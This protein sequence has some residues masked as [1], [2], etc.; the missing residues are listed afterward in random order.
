MSQ[1]LKW[2]GIS[3][4]VGGVLACLLTPLMSIGYY[5]SY[6]IPAESPPFWFASVQPLVGFLFSFADEKTAYSAY[7]RFFAVVYLLF[8]PGVLA[9]HKLHEK[10]APS[11]L[12]KIAYFLLVSALVVSFFG[13]S[14]DYW[15]IKA[16]WTVEL[17][18]M[19]FLQ[20]ATTLY[21]IAVLRLKIVPRSIAIIM[22]VSVPLCIISFLLFKQI[23]AAPS[24]PFATVSLAAGF[25]I[26]KFCLEPRTTV[27]K[28]KAKLEKL[29]SNRNSKNIKKDE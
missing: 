22:V 14:G 27:M 8:L 21:G 3:A 11:R 2:W 10:A 19:L 6:A 18:G 7:G 1:N 24:L 9:L 29:P 25:F 15:G 16:G 20:I 5:Q 28:G 17:L 23:P 12:E 4:I 13:V 26:L